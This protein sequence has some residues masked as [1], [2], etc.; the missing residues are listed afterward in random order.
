MD[1]QE[2]QVAPAVAEARELA[3]AAAR[4]VLDRELGDPSLSLEARITISEANSMPVVRRSS[5]G[6]TS[7]RSARMPQWASLMPVPEEQ[8]EESREDRVAD[9]AVQPRHRARLDVVHPV[10]DHHLGAVLELGD[11][12][13]DLLEVVGEVGVGH[14]DVL[15][16]GGGEAGEVGAA[17]AAAALV[18]D[19]RAGAL[20][21]QRRLVLGGVVGDDDLARP[22]PSARSLP[23]P[24]TTQASMFSASFRQGITTETSGLEDSSPSA[25]R[26]V[27]VWTAMLMRS[28]RPRR[29][30]PV[31]AVLTRGRTKSG[32]TRRRC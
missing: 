14:H 15:A 11:E 30:G 21:E 27:G 18:D 23:S 20:G 16:A 7:R 13:R 22:R 25:R 2:A 19:A 8:V 17:V 26:G 9:V 1:E 24:P 32:G 3:L 10:A 6:S 4:V 28:A 5:R 12:A 29:R 31:H